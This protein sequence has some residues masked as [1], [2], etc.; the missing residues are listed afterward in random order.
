MTP[1]PM[2]A[3]ALLAA[4]SRAP[5]RPAT[6]CLDLQGI[7]RHQVCRTLDTSRL[8]SEPDICVCGGDTVKVE[9]PYCAPGEAP[10]AETAAFDRARYTASAKDGTLVGKSFAGRSFCVARPGPRR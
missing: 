3:F 4:T 10:Q 2:L 1:A 6:L 9:A 8:S 5:E 7:N